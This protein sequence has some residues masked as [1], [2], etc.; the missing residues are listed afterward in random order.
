MNVK[1]TF[2]REGEKD[3]RRGGER[4]RREKEV[5]RDRQREMENDRDRLSEVCTW[6][7]GVLA[8]SRVTF[9]IE[10]LHLSPSAGAIP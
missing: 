1:N 2:G 4:E 6:N 7:P 10:A 9:S 5:E 3:I 8:N